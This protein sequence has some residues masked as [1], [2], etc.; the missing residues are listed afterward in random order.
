MAMTMLKTC[1]TSPSASGPNCPNFLAEDKQLEQICSI[2]CSMRSSLLV[3]KSFVQSSIF[4]A[5]RMDTG[6][7]FFCQV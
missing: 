2:F 1:R 4:L 6:E 3:L 7:W 5:L